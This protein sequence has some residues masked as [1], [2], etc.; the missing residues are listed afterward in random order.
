MCCHNIFDLYLCR[1]S[2]DDGTA[3]D[4]DEAKLQP[5]IRVLDSGMTIEDLAKGNVG[6]KI[7]S[8]GKK[9]IPNLLLHLTR[10]CLG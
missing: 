1:V 7:A 10:L 6:A 8:C 3:E 4:N 5:R 9:V 2:E